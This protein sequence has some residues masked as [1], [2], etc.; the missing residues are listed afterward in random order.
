MAS[1]WFRK[2]FILA[3]WLAVALLLFAFSA[4][5]A[6]QAEQRTPK[7]PNIVV[8]VIDDLDNHMGT[9]NHMPFLQSRLVKEG[10]TFTNAVVTTALCCPTRTTFLTGLLAHVGR[11]F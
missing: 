6:A 2:A 3:T 5:P 7:K 11:E 8:F 9:M 1:N 10:T 4:L